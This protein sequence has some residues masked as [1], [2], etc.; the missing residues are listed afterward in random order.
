LTRLLLKTFKMNYDIGV[1]QYNLLRVFMT[2]I[3]ATLI[4]LAV[5]YNTGLNVNDKIRFTKI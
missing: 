3:E 5:E 2:Y 1:T 4:D